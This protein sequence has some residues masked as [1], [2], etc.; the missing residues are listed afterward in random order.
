MISGY[1][2][3]W[4]F[5]YSTPPGGD[6]CEC[7]LGNPNLSN[8]P[9]TTTTKSPA[10]PTSAT[11]S[12]LQKFLNLLTPNDISPGS[13][14]FS[15][16]VAPYSPWNGPPMDTI[17]TLGSNLVKQTNYRTVLIYYTEP[18]L[19][20][21][22]VRNGMNVFGIISLGS[23]VT[24]NE[25]LIT[26]AIQTV[27]KYPNNMV[28]LVCGNELGMQLGVT[29]S[30]A[31]IINN[32]LTKVK[33]A[34]LGIP[35]G[36][37]DTFTAW[38][39]SGAWSAVS[40]NADYIGTSKLLFFIIYLPSDIYSWW[41][42]MYIPPPFTCQT[43]A[44]GPQTTYNNYLKVQA[45]YPKTPVILTEFGWPSCGAGFTCKTPNVVD[46][47]TCA[48]ANDS[49]Q[50]QFVQNVINIFRQ[51][52]KP[53]NT[54]SAFREAWK[55]TNSADINEYWGVCSGSPPYSCINAPS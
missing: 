33:A 27:Q 32:C 11:T 42:N 10:L 45:L 6:Q 50:K 1:S 54:F 48:V 19:V 52:K 47:S 53:C 30:T 23:D 3:W 22:C 40:A 49:N 29:T 39:A 25:N 35:V 51:N 5:G 9:T 34:N 24:N 28:G 21:S 36:V 17:D 20:G 14:S 13:V 18:Y 41:D 44:N 16:Y 55:G 26:T 43:P 12:A 37:M 15:P 31:A 7:I 46:G 4:D 38:T 8:T 2:H